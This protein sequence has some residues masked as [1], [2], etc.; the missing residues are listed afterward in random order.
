MPHR[1]WGIEMIKYI[2]CPGTVISKNDGDHHYVS[3]DRLIHLYCV[4]RRECIIDS[5]GRFRDRSYDALIKLYPRYDGNYPLF[6]H[7]P[8]AGN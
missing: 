2:I 6:S 1:A 3:A 8:G 4:D 7:P 5:L